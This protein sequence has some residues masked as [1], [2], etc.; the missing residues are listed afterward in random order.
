MQT[1]N[2]TISIFLILLTNTILFTFLFSNYFYTQQKIFRNEERVI[3]ELQKGELD[4]YFEQAKSDL[5]L[6]DD[7][8]EVQYTDADI[9]NNKEK[10]ESIFIKFAN[11]K[12][13]YDQ[14]RFIDKEGMEK[15]RVNYAYNSSIVVPDELLQDKSDRYYFKQTKALEKEQLYL[16]PFDLNVENGSIEYPYKIVIRIST[17]LFN[18]NKEFIGILVLNYHANSLFSS[19]NKLSEQITNKFFFLNSE[20]FY[21]FSPYKAQEWSYLFP[22]NQQYKFQEDYPQIWESIQNKTDAQFFEKGFILTYENY[23]PFISILNNNS[24]PLLLNGETWKIVSMISAKSILKNNLTSWL[25]LLFFYLLISTM[26][27]IIFLNNTRL[28]IQSELVTISKNELEQSNE[29]LEQVVEERTADLKKEVE[30]R[31][32]LSNNLLKQKNILQSI[33]KAS[34]DIIFLKDESLKYITVNSAFE[35]W[36]N[37]PLDEIIGKTDQQLLEPTIAEFFKQNDYQVLLYNETARIEKE[38]DTAHGKHWFDIYIIPVII[39]ANNKP[40]ILGIARNITELTSKNEEIKKFKVAIETSTSN[41]VITNNRAEIEYANKGFLKL[42]GYTFDEI[43]GKNPK[44]INSKYHNKDFYIHLW[45]TLASKKEWRGEFRNISKQGNYFWESASIVP[46][47][48][49]KGEV[50]NYIKVSHDIT[51]LKRIEDDLKKSRDQLKLIADNLPILISYVG[52][53]HR[54]QFV[55]KGYQDWFNIP[56]E[57][58]VGKHMKEIIG[59]E[60]YRITKEE[61]DK[62][63]KGELIS[64]EKK[65]TYKNGITRIVQT[66]MIPDINDNNEVKG[67]FGMFVDVTKRVEAEQFLIASENRFRSMVEKIDVGIYITDELGNFDYVNPCFCNIYGYSRDELIGQNFTKVIPLSEQKNRTELHHR[68]IESNGKTNLRNEYETIDSK[69]KII[70]ALTDATL[71]FNDQGEKRKLT[72]VID[73]TKNKEMVKE[74]EKAKNNAENAN[75]AK[76]IFLANMSHEI[77][78]PLNSIIGFSRLI[79]NKLG[80]NRILKNYSDTIRTSG[81]SLLSLINDIL[82]LARIEAGKIEIQYSETNLQKFIAEIESNYKILSS[83]KPNINFKVEVKNKIPSHIIIDKLRL[84]QIINNLLNNAIKF[85]EKGYIE[86]HIWSERTQKNKTNLFFEVHDSGIGIPELEKQKI[87]KSF[88]QRTMQNTSKYGGSGL[89]LAISQQLAQNMNGNISLTSEENVGSIF[90]LL[91]KEVEFINKLDNILDK[92]E[93]DQITSIIF[94]PTKILLVDDIDYNNQLIVESFKHQPFTF[95]IASNGK[96]AIAKAKEFEPEL[97]LMDMRMPEMNGIEATKEIRKIKKFRTIPVI[98][99]TASVLRVEN[100]ELNDFFDNVLYKPLDVYQLEQLLM[101]YIKHQKVEQKAE[102]VKLEHTLFDLTRQIENKTDLIE[103]LE[104]QIKPKWEEA[105]NSPFMD[106]SQD[107]GKL[108]MSIGNEF[109]ID[110]L[111]SYGQT[112]I[113]YADSYNLTQ[114]KTELDNFRIIFKQT[115]N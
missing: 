35:Y 85:T 22:E 8:I 108:I 25:F 47:L 76:S 100:I 98:C 10:I 70:I 41:F 19:L 2:K 26:S 113:D 90:K 24:K 82:D 29:N 115:K 18:S 42:T 44:I 64:Y 54:Y 7:L 40:G 61:L 99:I 84:K 105:I 39:D 32:E 79:S 14:I 87:F 6:L 4:S 89:G 9:L 91:L 71:F 67:C 114:L 95:E 20:G 110:Y 1:R 93:S 81:K 31:I 112:I 59:D 107:F 53:D 28:R 94:E 36:A 103:I 58:I 37:K 46:L 12:K 101:L 50:V 45:K 96:E 111:I 52:E 83:E 56:A 51:Q 65:N 13:H 92:E 66:T 5:F 15:I 34:P 23:T 97:I 102:P 48:N 72:F 11:Q 57:E 16:S 80:E 86:L 68:F 63:F 73:V 30:S 55:N 43:K 104:T 77:R 78:T 49:E 3:L 75:Q 106:P 74:L 88:E 109:K 38:F 27:V 60:V 62:V 69:S 17:P 21:L 33:L